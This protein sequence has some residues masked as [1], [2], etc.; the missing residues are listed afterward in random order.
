MNKDKTSLKHIHIP[1]GNKYIINQ[2]VQ[3]DKYSHNTQ[4]N[5]KIL[6]KITGT[7]Y[8][9]NS[10]DTLKNKKILIISLLRNCAHNTQKTLHLI[11]S[12]NN[13]YHSVYY[14][15]FSNN[16][17]DRTAH[18]W[19]QIKNEC[20]YIDGTIYN[21]EKIHVRQGRSVGNRINKLA[22]YRN[23]LFENAINTFDINF[24]YVIV[25]D[26]D[27]FTAPSAWDIAKATTVDISQWSCISGNY[28]YVNTLCYY[29]AL[30]LRF[31]GQSN[32]IEDIYPDFN[33]YYGINTNWINQFYAF[34]DYVEVQ[35]AFG[36][37][38]IYHYNELINIYNTYKELYTVHK[39]YTS[40][41]EH[42]TLSHR[43]Q[44]P[45]FIDSNIYFE[46][47]NQLEGMI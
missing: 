3:S 43:L 6:K 4:H 8:K 32:Y 36:G 27:F 16:N 15:F 42:I 13:I 44:H 12:L 33:R 26:G 9:Y 45:Q 41:C 30:S 47:M 23:I 37:I 20:K 2:L 35:S 11:N 38:C 17:I 40:L 25:L 22:Q 7:Q 39:E 10:I 19:N 28:C 46:A 14:Y 21:N 24:D 1:D 29:D 18:K 31:I 5:Q 34:T